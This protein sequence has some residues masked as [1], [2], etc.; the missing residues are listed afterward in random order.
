MYDGRFKA[1]F[2]KIYDEEYRDAF[3]KAGITYFYTLIDDAV[4]RVIRSG[5]GFVTLRPSGSAEF[6]GKRLQVSAEGTF[7]PAGKSVTVTGQNGLT[8]LVKAAEE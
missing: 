5:G 2:Q 6:G 7:I 8:V 1:V 4:S 3:E